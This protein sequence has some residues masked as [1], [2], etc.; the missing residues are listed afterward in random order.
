MTNKQFSK[1]IK[2]F[3][4]QQDELILLKGYDYTMGQHELDRLFN[5]KWVAGVLGISPLQVFAVYWLKHILAILTYIKT[6]VVK[7]EALASRFLDEN[8]Y[9]L[10]GYSLI[11]ELQANQK[12]RKRKACKIKRKASK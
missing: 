6:G 2:K 10:L 8:N 5:F 3:R 7:S 1:L 11:K 9:N 4:K 12:K